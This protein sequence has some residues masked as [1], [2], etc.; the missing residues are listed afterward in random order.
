MGVKKSEVKYKFK[1]NAI[2]N[3]YQN[4]LKILR[5]NKP[6]MWRL[7]PVLKGEMQT[8]YLISICPDKMQE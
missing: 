6:L 4:S 5:P 3:I 1:A 8:G 7:L 2:C